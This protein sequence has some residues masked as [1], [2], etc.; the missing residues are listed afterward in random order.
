V[1]DASVL[2]ELRER[3]ALDSLGRRERE[4]AELLAGGLSIKQIAARIGISPFTVESH[5]DNIDRKL[6]VRT[7]AALLQGLQD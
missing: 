6:G 4:V 1:R 2:V 5:R 7:R 3:R